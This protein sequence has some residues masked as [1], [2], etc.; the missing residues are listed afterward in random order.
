MAQQQPSFG[1][2]LGLLYKRWTLDCIPNLGH[3]VSVDFSTRPELYKQVNAKTAQQLTDL[4][5]EYGFEPNFPNDTIRVMLMKPIFGE[6]DGSGSGHDG[7]IFQSSRMPVLAA[8]ADFA[9]NAQPTAFPMHRERTRSAIIP[10]RRFMEDLEGASLNQTASRI[11]SI[12]ET[13]ASVLKDTDIAS[14]FGVNQAINQNWPLDS[15]DSGGAKL[16]E[17]V[18]TQLANTSYGVIS[19]NLWVRWQRKAQ[20]GQDSIQFIL[21]NDIE[22]I[23][24]TDNSLD[25]LIRLLYAWGSDLGLVGGATPQ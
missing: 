10:F 2:R 19:P 23:K 25:D 18:T 12:F 3:A 16:I 24:V 7:S 9:E 17:K 11:E 6:S 8:A 15:T 5:S 14:V 4:Q 22:S 20:E 1:Q 21:E 13:A